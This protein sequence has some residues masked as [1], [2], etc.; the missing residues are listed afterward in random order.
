MNRI[1]NT[2]LLYYDFKIFNA[3]LLVKEI[4]YMRNSDPESVTFD[5]F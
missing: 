1:F 4:F 3:Q 5:L 2:C